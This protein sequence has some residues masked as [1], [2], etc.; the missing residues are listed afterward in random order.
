MSIPFRS[1]PGAG[2]SE[3]A[4]PIITPLSDWS[5]INGSQPISR[6]GGTAVLEFAALGGRFA[7]QVNIVVP[8]RTIGIFCVYYFHTF[9]ELLLHLMEL[10]LLSLP[11]SNTRVG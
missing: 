5:L 7:P 4:V 1:V 11:I 8:S 10:D 2:N 9:N 3:R 6:A